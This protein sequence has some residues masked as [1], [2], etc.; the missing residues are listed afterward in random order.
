M[1]KALKA[2]LATGA[3]FRPDHC[4]TKQFLTLYGDPYGDGRAAE[5]IVQAIVEIAQETKRHELCSNVPSL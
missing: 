2:D 1:T 4:R 5:R 3:A